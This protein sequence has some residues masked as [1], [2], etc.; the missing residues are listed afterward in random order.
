MGENPDKSCEVLVAPAELQE[1]PPPDEEE[2]G[3]ELVD[4]HEGEEVEP[5]RK[6]ASL[7]MPSAADVE[8]H[9]LTHVP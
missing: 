4:G 9:R 6:A 2:G 5:L 3:T 1:D 7:E 8:E